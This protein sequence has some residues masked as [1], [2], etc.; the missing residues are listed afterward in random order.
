MV[1]VIDQDWNNGLT[2]DDIHI[3]ETLAGFVQDTRKLNYCGIWQN[4]YLEARGTVLS[5]DL[6]V[7][8]LDIASGAVQ[9]GVTLVN[10]QAQ[11]R[12]VTVKTAVAD[13][14]PPRIPI[15]YPPAAPCPS[16]CR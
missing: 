9:V 6:F 16:L 2:D 7:E 5:Q 10:A 14:R 8:T 15:Q 13:G 1:R 11:P 12:T 3:K 4:V